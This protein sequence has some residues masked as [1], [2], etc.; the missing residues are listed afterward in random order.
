MPMKHTRMIL[1]ACLPILAACHHDARPNW[2]RAEAAPHLTIPD[3]IDTPGRSAEMSVPA[4]SGQ[5]EG[6]VHDDTSPPT[7][8]TMTSDQETGVAWQTVTDRLQAS[9]TAQVVSRDSQEHDLSVSIK[10]SQLP[11]PDGGFFSRMFRSKADPERDYFA[12]ISVASEN[13]ETL[14]TLD[15]DGRAVLYFGHLLE[16]KSL[17]FAKSKGGS[18]SIEDRRNRVPSNTGA[19]DA[20]GRRR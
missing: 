5:V 20:S 16:G 2:Q 11:K 13:G 6:A 12:H 10:G 8:L 4:A 14:V 1:I 7:S 3:G 17:Q 9:G 18:V 19:P 15:G